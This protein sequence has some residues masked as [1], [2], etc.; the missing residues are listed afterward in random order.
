M[1]Q[2]SWGKACAHAQGQQRLVCSNKRQPFGIR[3]LSLAGGT[4]LCTPGWRPLKNQSSLKLDQAWG[5]WAKEGQRQSGGVRS[6]QNWP[7]PPFSSLPQAF[8]GEQEP[9]LPHPLWPA[10]SP[11]AWEQAL[12][13]LAQLWLVPVR[14]EN[15]TLLPDIDLLFWTRGF[16]WLSSFTPTVA[17]GAATSWPGFVVRVVAHLWES[18]SCQLPIESHPAGLDSQNTG[19]S[20]VCHVWESG[21]VLGECGGRGKENCYLICWR[22]FLLPYT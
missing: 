3:V 18:A 17:T 9:A 6:F 2:S 21:W 5:T 14:E 15:P 10:A 20:G 12:Q 7:T 19:Q 11:S 13:I 16:P 1:H 4:H 22:F 8:Q